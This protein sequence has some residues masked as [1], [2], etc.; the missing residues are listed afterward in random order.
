[1]CKHLLNAI[2]N[3]G[4]QVCDGSSENPDD[5]SLLVEESTYAY[6]YNM[7]PHVEQQ[8]RLHLTVEVEQQISIR[9]S[10]QGISPH[11]LAILIGN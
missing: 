3:N 9:R 1:M 5:I 4:T 6:A 10:V 7:L 2:M 8:T 11:D